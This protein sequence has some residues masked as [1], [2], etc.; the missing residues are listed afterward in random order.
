MFFQIRSI[1][2]DVFGW[3]DHVQDSLSKGQ[4]INLSVEEESK[5]YNDP[6]ATVASTIDTRHGSYATATGTGYN[7]DEDDGAADEY[8]FF[9]QKGVPYRVTLHKMTELI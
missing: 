3:L 2:A 9:E 5:N 7:S 4:S 1:K 8:S 6:D